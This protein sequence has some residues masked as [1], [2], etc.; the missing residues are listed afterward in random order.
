MP[1]AADLGCG[2]LSAHAQSHARHHRGPGQRALPRGDDVRRH[3]QPG[4]RRVRRRSSTA[5]STP[6]STSSTRRTSTLAASPRP[7]SARRSPGAAT[8]SCWRRSSTARWAR[9]RT[10]PGNSRRW[11][12]REVE[13]SLRR[14]GTDWIDVYQVHRPDP[15]D[16][17]RGHPGGARR[18]RPRRQDPLRRVLD[19]PRRADRRGPLGGRPPGRRALPHR[20]AAVLD[21]RPRHRAGSAPDVRALRDGRAR[22]EPAERRLAHRALPPTADVE[23]HGADG[24]RMPQRFD[25][26]RPGQPAQARAGRRARQARRRGRDRTC[27]GWRSASCSPTRP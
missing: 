1:S 6:G 22:V 10:C 8:T 3:G 24:S 5:R 2:V 12:V 23:P 25:L 19:V 21:L 27:S 26:D 13:D 17:H 18:P 15:R 9:A 16:R 7:S 20:A 4:P 14:L 11:I